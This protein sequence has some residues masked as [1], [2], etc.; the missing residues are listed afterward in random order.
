MTLTT[1]LGREA[2]PDRTNPKPVDDTLINLHYIWRITV[3]LLSFPQ[4]ECDTSLRRMMETRFTSLYRGQSYFQPPGYMAHL[5]PPYHS[6]G[7]SRMW[8][9]LL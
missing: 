1:F 6:S 8:P 9:D 7:A 5:H 4:L 2:I 3:A